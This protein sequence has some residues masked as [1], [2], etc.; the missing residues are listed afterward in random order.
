MTAFD[1]ASNL[2][3]ESLQLNPRDRSLLALKSTILP[4]VGRVNECRQL[5]DFERLVHQVQVCDAGT[6]ESIQTGT[7]RTVVTFP[8]GF[9]ASIDDFNR[10]LATHVREHPSLTR[11]PLS[12]ATRDGYHSGPLRVS[13]KGP[14]AALE[15]LMVKMG[16]QYMKRVGVDPQ[17]PFLREPQALGMLNC[18]GVVMRGQGHQTSHIHPAAWLSGVYYPQVPDSFDAD[19]SQAGCIEFGIAPDQFGLPPSAITHTVKPCV[20]TD[21][22]LSVLF[23]SPHHTLRVRAGAHQH[24]LRSVA[25]ASVRTGWDGTNRLAGKFIGWL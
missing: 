5:L 10:A 3:D 11:E 14:I 19:D 22:H 20:G 15:Q 18:W 9:G 13:P 7:G 21:G 17:H 8:Q 6:E 1:Q 12:H 16:R 25:V 2:V 23:L 4:L 24:R